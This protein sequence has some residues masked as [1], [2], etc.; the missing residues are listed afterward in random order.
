MEVL[1][2][3]SSHDL[4]FE[5]AEYDSLIIDEY[6]WIRFRI[7]TCE[8]LWCATEKTY[9]ILAITNSSPGNGHFNDVLEWFENSCRRD[10]KALKFL[11]VWNKGFK[12][13]LIEKRGFK[14][15]GD[16]VIKIFK[17]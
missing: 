16:N 1:E 17:K 11:E 2:F 9:N 6:N 7:G 3:R 8:G 14:K 4:Y 13:N 5:C 12:N 10:K 15:N